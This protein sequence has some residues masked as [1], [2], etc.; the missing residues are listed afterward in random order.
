MQKIFI[1]CSSKDAQAALTI[2]NAIEARGHD[3]WLASRD[4][5]PGQN[6]QEEIVRAIHAAAL[7]VLVFSA[8]ANNSNEIK[9]ELAIASQG[10]LTVIPVRIEDVTPAGAFVYELATRQWIDLFGDWERAMQTLLRNIKAA[11]PQQAMAPAAQNPPVPPPQV[12]PA[13]SMRTPTARPASRR[14]LLLIFVGVVVVLGGVITLGVLNME[15]KSA[16]QAAAANQKVIT[17]TE[18]GEIYLGT[19]KMT[20]IALADAFRSKNQ[21]SIYIRGDQNAQFESVARALSAIYS[22]SVKLITLGE[23]Q[24]T[25]GLPPVELPATGAPDLQQPIELDFSAIHP[26]DDSHHV[27]VEVENNG[28]VEWGVGFAEPA[29]QA[30][31]A[32]LMEQTRKLNP[33]TKIYVFPR[34]QV[35]Y[36]AITALIAHAQQHGLRNISL[37][38]N[39]L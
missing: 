1:S 38:F 32:E 26:V 22:V 36:S 10:G 12:V 5:G 15:Q 7:M 11:L 30:K 34:G 35:K 21:T 20:D 8:N 39:W 4:V 18:Y 9:K 16:E 28:T 13:T 3:C 23:P 29:Q 33:T 24:G 27:V 6:Y 31:L 17:V 25:K 37:N 14:K 2:C 19:Q